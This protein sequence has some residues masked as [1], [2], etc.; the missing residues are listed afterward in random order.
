M[1]APLNNEI[2]QV[3]EMLGITQAQATTLLRN[4]N[5][6][7][8]RSI[9]AYFND[10]V[11]SLT[12]TNL[13]AHNTWEQQDN[14]PFDGDDDA[15]ST[16]AMPALSR[17]PSRAEQ[18][19][20]GGGHVN[21]IDLTQAHAQATTQAN[22]GTTQEQDEEAQL[23]EAMRLSLAEAQE[24]GVTSTD[25]TG[26]AKGDRYF[27]PATRNEYDASQ[28]QMVAVASSREIVDH[29]PPS[30]RRRMNGQ[31]AFLRPSNDKS[32]LAALLTIYHAIPMARE[33]LLFPSM[34]VASYGYDPSWWSGTS[35]ANSRSISMQTD[36]NHDVDR[37]KA[38]AEVQCLM[39]FLDNTQRAYGSVDALQDLAFMRKHQRTASTA[40]SV[41]LEAW[42]DAA[43]SQQPNESLAG[44]FHS[45]A[46]RVSEMD[47]EQT[48][49]MV[50]IEPQIYVRP[51]Q[52]LVNLLDTTV[53]D[54]T[55]GQ[56]LEDV[57]ISHLG[58]VFTIRIWGDA[59]LCAEGLQLTAPATWYPDR[60]MAALREQTRQMRAEVQK[61]RAQM[62]E[63][64]N[65]QRRLESFIGSNRRPVR[66]REVLEAAAKAAPTILNDRYAE[67]QPNEELNAANVAAIEGQI[68]A[69]LARIEEKLA[70][71]ESKK[72]SLQKEI[73]VL[74][75]QY[76]GPGDDPSQP[77]NLNYMLT[78]VATKPEVIYV[79]QR[80]H[81][82]LGLEDDDAT[83][84][85]D[86]W[87]WWRIAWSP[88]SS[89][90]APSI[91]PVSQPQAQVPAT[92]EHN[93]GSALPDLPYTIA[94]VSESDA[95][96]AVRT[97]YHTA[98]LVYAS[99]KALG[100]QGRTLPTA[101]RQMIEQDNISFGQDIRSEME[102]ETQAPHGT[103]N[104]MDDVP[105]LVDNTGT[106]SDTP[107]GRSPDGFGAAERKFS[108]M[109]I[110][111]SSYRDEHGQPSPKRPKSSHESDGTAGVVYEDNTGSPPS[112]DDSVL[113][114]EE[115]QAQ[116]RYQYRNKIGEYADSLSKMYGDTAEEL[117]RMHGNPAGGGS[118]PGAGSGSQI[119]SIEQQKG[120]SVHIERSDS[121]PR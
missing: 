19:G 32:Y 50:C 75:L 103:A 6:D 110:G 107:T 37:T 5:N 79:R 87:Q 13:A 98:V 39:A 43:R 96:E 69:V 100:F 42:Q 94:E 89:Q 58:D 63:I 56:P 34:Q 16:G 86:E 47:N 104:I 25:P 10:A 116:Q 64:T 109:S 23:Q 65:Q 67:H 97:E 57:Y 30:K 1:S 28:W 49:G 38:L 81:D 48:R 85:R 121:P 82:L 55:D 15:R 36:E 114:T 11:G 35:D 24:S 111:T 117:S 66:I 12:E 3:V 119:N 46:K 83:R 22:A 70:G 2:S 45:E 17:P 53:W 99:E 31:P 91:G 113:P 90:K 54:D 29:P 41:F 71:L 101:L 61:I 68:R 51:N 21:P 33:A 108:A 27:G 44:I 26:N 102:P 74:E 112:Y 62:Y 115:N 120:E 14:I 40:F 72:N 8:S 92:D 93:Q 77:P 52:T 7:V 59:N 76:T 9:D 4:N 20:G 78:G 88:S 80:S 84:K 18:S 60:Y 118:G 106:S 105:D 73:D 95:I